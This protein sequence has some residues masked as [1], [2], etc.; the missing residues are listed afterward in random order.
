METD[1]VYQVKP[2]NL[3]G[4]ARQAWKTLSSTFMPKAILNICLKIQAL[5][6]ERDWY[7]E[8]LE[9]YE[10]AVPFT[11][12]KSLMYQDWEATTPLT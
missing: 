5:E 12:P 4:L 3:S 8:Q 9:A 11:D 7:K 6:F 10:E 2:E 1:P